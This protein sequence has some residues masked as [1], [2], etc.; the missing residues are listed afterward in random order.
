MGTGDRGR[1]GAGVF[2]TV[3]AAVAPSPTNTGGTKT[4][5][6][7]LPPFLLLREKNTTLPPFCCGE[8]RLKKHRRHFC[9]L[10]EKKQTCIAAIPAGEQSLIKHPPLEGFLQSHERSYI[11]ERTKKRRSKASKH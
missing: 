8:Q 3:F 5:K 7:T 10:W 2:A 9:S 6:H 4:N 11:A 1:G